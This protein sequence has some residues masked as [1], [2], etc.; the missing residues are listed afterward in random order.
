MASSARTAGIRGGAVAKESLA[1][2]A[3]AW[4]QARDEEAR[5]KPAQDIAAAPRIAD[6]ESRTASAL[7]DVFRTHDETPFTLDDDAAAEDS[8][9]GATRASIMALLASAEQTVDVPP[10]KPTRQKRKR[11]PT[12]GV[13]PEGTAVEAQTETAESD[14]APEKKPRRARASRPGAAVHGRPGRSMSA[15]TWRFTSCSHSSSG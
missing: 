3:R 13:D 6:P 12:P 10:L 2:V 1:T 11:G 15:S 9:P 7:A 5:S 4:K 14:Q 8:Q